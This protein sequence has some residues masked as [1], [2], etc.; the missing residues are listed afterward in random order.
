MPQGGITLDSIR[1]HTHGQGNSIYMSKWSETQGNKG[2]GANYR[3]LGIFVFTLYS[4]FI[5]WDI[6][7]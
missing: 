6:Y 7:S 3:V 5:Y 2:K 4:L 1:V